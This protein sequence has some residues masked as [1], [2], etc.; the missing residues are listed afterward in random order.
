[1]K[2]FL[3]NHFSGIQPFV[4]CVFGAVASSLIPDRTIAIGLTFL[5]VLL[6][7]YFIAEI[8]TEGRYPWEDK[9]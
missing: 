1:M 2:K 7:L 4:M 6:F 8:W 5:F 9:E 3:Q